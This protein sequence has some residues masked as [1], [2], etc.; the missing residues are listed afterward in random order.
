MENKLNVE[1]KGEVYSLKKDKTYVIK[2]KKDSV[3][4]EELD[5]ME[6]I[7]ISRGIDIVFIVLNDINDMKLEG[8]FGLD[9]PE[10]DIYTEK[11]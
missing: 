7:F 4:L 9:D 1:F 11:D 3:K 6:K 8:N 5:R 10:E 2:V